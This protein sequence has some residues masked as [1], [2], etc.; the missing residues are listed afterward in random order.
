MR[1]AL[2]VLICCN[3]CSISFAENNEIFKNSSILHVG[4]SH[5][6][7]KFDELMLSFYKEYFFDANVYAVGGSSPHHWNESPVS[8]HLCSGSK[9]G[10]VNEKA[11][12]SLKNE[13][14]NKDIASGY[15][16]LSARLYG[17]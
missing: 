15:Q 4:D 2:I 10:R 6:V 16:E 7:G 14:C 5:T 3:F 12:I 1:S 9:N 8:K 17:R 13:V 11:G